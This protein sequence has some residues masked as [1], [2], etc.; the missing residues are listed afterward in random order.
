LASAAG[1]FAKAVVPSDA[2]SQAFD[3]LRRASSQ[4]AHRIQPGRVPLAGDKVEQEIR[5][6]C[7]SRLVELVEGRKHLRRQVSQC[8]RDLECLEGWSEHLRSES[9]YSTLARM[10]EGGFKGEG[11][12]SSQEVD[13]RAKVI[14]FV[15]LLYGSED[16][17]LGRMLSCLTTNPFHYPALGQ[18]HPDVVA[19]KEYCDKVLFE[20]TKNFVTT[21]LVEILEAEQLGVVLFCLT[22]EPKHYE[23]LA[24]LLSN[25]AG[26]QYCDHLLSAGVQPMPTRSPAQAE[27]EE[28]AMM[29]N[30]CRDR[31]GPEIRR[32][33]DNGILAPGFKYG[34]KVAQTGA[35]LPAASPAGVTHFTGQAAAFTQ[36]AADASGKMAEAL[37]AAQQSTLVTSEAT[38]QAA[39]LSKYA[40][41]FWL[42]KS[43][44]IVA[45][46][47]Q[48]QV[49]VSQ[50]AVQVA[51]AESASCTALAQN[52]DTLAK[53][54]PYAGYAG[55]VLTVSFMGY[56][57]YNQIRRYYKHEIDGYKCAENLTA[58]ILSTGAGFV[59]GCIGTVLVA[60]AGP[61]GVVL[62]AVAGSIIGAGA[63]RS[64]VHGIFQRMFGTDRQRAVKDAY[65]VLGLSEGA[66]SGEIRKQYL[67]LAK[68]HHPDKEHG[69]QRKFIEVNCAY[70]LIR[71]S[72]LSD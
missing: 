2:M 46:G 8:V 60:G 41:S 6:A 53:C 50:T 5:H 29:L 22:T 16:S 11:D 31:F 28:A 49:R 63:V 27:E 23:A 56:E 48:Q 40:K 32:L 68:Q 42:V 47:A 59:G 39:S 62:G 69:S 24:F 1:A 18:L 45:Q 15:M 17:K 71:A 55:V 65:G 57:L 19:M 34:V 30:E 25:H 52:S 10:G 12:H 35:W 70:E 4:A 36:Q 72:L 66:S 14:S 20:N 61:A 43:H 21:K 44:E 38:K 54:S 3:T 33:E 13:L 58:T 64:N 7:C 37:Q 9:V 51:S 26:M 67:G